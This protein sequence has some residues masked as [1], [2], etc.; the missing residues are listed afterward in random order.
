MYCTSEKNSSLYRQPT[1]DVDIDEVADSNMEIPLKCV[2]HHWWLIATKIPTN[3]HRLT[4][5]NSNYTVY[6]RVEEVFW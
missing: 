5:I 1:F 3:P 6:C 4:L 2:L